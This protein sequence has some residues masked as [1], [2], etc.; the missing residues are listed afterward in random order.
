MATSA[1]ERGGGGEI[2]AIEK[3]L[4]QGLVVKVGDKS[5]Y[6]WQGQMVL[7]IRSIVHPSFLFGETKSMLGPKAFPIVDVLQ[8]ELVSP[9]SG[10]TIRINT[11]E[12][13]IEFALAS[14]DVA[15]QAHLYISMYHQFCCQRSAEKLSNVL[16]IEGFHTLGPTCSF[17]NGTHTVVIE[18]WGGAICGSAMHIGK[19]S[20][21]MRMVVCGQCAYVGLC[22]I[23]Y[24]LNDAPGEKGSWSINSGGGMMNDGDYTDGYHTGWTSK[25]LLRIE[26][27][28]DSGEVVC[29]CNNTEIVHEMVHAART[30]TPLCFCAGNSGLVSE[31]NITKPQTDEA[32][33]AIVR[34]EQEATSVAIARF[35]LQLVKGF[36]VQ[37][38]VEGV[39]GSNSKTAILFVRNDDADT[40]R[41][42]PSKDSPNPTRFPMSKVSEITLDGSETKRVITVHSTGASEFPVVFALASPVVTE[43]IAQLLCKLHKHAAMER[44]AVGTGSRLAGMEKKPKKREEPGVRIHGGQMMIGLYKLEI[45]VVDVGDHTAVGLCVP[46]KCDQQQWPGLRESGSSWAVC[47]TGTMRSEGRLDQGHHQR[48]EKG[49]R[50]SFDFDADQGILRWRHNGE[51]QGELVI[52]VSPYEE[53]GL[54]FCI[55]SSGELNTG[56][57]VVGQEGAQE[58]CHPENG[59]EEEEEEEGMGKDE[60]GDDEESPAAQVEAEAK[61]QGMMRQQL[62]QGIMVRQFVS[63]KNVPSAP[64]TWII[65][66]KPNDR[67]HLYCAASK[68]DAYPM[69]IAVQDMA[70]ELIGAASERRIRVSTVGGGE[71]NFGLATAAMTEMFAQAMERFSV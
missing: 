53:G 54:Y 56:K 37:H 27:N 18:D 39:G 59:L 22:G 61:R 17:K 12:A 40:L 31:I 46:A 64:Q 58:Y 57:V 14:P 35:R 65:F 63:G 19:H 3:W 68:E 70:V 1:A 43:A 50:L 51:E 26:Y 4:L 25:D 33:A 28:A 32:A 69:V 66:A 8:I 62:L 6:E 49:S 52:P 13:A 29:W 55:A 45:S 41:F 60:V 24:D 16:Q 44:V 36:L 5:S 38:Y 10:S 23:G 30:P 11:R 67:T 9:S 2:A 42:A 34:V 15:R 7:Y 71:I 20:I 21:E 48:W 47:A